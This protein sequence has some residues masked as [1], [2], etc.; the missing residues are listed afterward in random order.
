MI[1]ERSEPS[2]DR[3]PAVERVEMSLVQFSGEAALRVTVK[4]VQELAR[5]LENRVDSASGRTDLHF[6]V[7]TDLRVRVIQVGE[8]SEEADKRLDVPIDLEPVIADYLARNTA[9]EL[10]LQE[11]QLRLV[12]S[13]SS[14]EKEVLSLVAQASARVS[15]EEG[16]FTED[17]SYDT[18]DLS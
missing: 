11:D 17:N 14:Q 13:G 3:P 1:D 6:G 4:A 7:L 18:E 10:N 15:S 8:D 9:L 2:N 12:Q 5:K 16:A